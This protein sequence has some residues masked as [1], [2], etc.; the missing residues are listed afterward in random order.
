MAHTTIRVLEL[1]TDANVRLTHNIDHA[2][3]TLSIS[4]VERPLQCYVEGERLVIGDYRSDGNR[5]SWAHRAGS[6]LSFLTCAYLLSRVSLDAFKSPLEVVARWYIT[7]TLTCWVMQWLL[8]K[9]TR[10]LMSWLQYSYRFT[11]HLVSLEE[12]H[13]GSEGLLM[14]DQSLMS[15]HVDVYSTGASLLFYARGT[16]QVQT[17]RL[18]M[19]GDARVHGH[20]ALVPQLQVVTR[21]G[22]G[23]VAGITATQQLTTVA[24]GEQRP[25]YQVL[26]NTT[27][28]CV[29]QRLA[30]HR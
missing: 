6:L 23:S 30:T 21:A 8:S 20:G 2:L 24:L 16:Q 26:V 17:M 5:Q 7:F 25:P 4:T 28:D 22:T 3:T 10:W 18:Y 19:G 29:V 9:V 27:S 13:L 15:T 11:V 14:L 12:L 1:R